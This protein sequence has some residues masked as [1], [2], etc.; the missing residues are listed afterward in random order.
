MKTSGS[1]FCDARRTD[2]IEYMHR[3]KDDMLGDWRKA[4]HCIQAAIDEM[5][6]QEN[7][8]ATTKP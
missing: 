7:I 6:T 8:N 2:A 1:V 3:I 4:L 5:E